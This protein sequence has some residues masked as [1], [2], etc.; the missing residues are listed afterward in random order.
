MKHHQVSS[1]SIATKTISS[2][3]ENLSKTS[4]VAQLQRSDSATQLKLPST[5]VALESTV[6]MPSPNTL[7]SITRE[8]ESSF[9]TARFTPA[10]TAFTSAVV[11]GDKKMATGSMSRISYSLGNSTSSVNVKPSPS[12][13]GKSNS[14]PARVSAIDPSEGLDIFKATYGKYVV[15][16]Q[17]GDFNKAEG[18]TESEKDKIRADLYDM[19]PLSRMQF[20]GSGSN[21]LGNGPR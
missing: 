8:L 19:N 10:T 7:E 4:K 2:S 21:S 5:S 11:E 12:N 17:D 20:T 6:P 16:P 18:P 1:S 15:K 14:A 3:T 9:A 13:S